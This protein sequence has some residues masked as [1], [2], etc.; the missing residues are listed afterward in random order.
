MGGSGRGVF[1]LGSKPDL[2]MIDLRTRAGKKKRQQ[3]V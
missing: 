1:F 2:K 3:E